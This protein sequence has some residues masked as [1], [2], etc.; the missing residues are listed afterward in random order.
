MERN[1]KNYNTN[2]I[3]IIYLDLLLNFLNQFQINELK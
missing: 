1:E 3:L 2:H